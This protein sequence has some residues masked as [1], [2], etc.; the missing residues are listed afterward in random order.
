MKSL[1]QLP[2]F[3]YWQ[4]RALFLVFFAIFFLSLKGWVPKSSAGYVLPIHQPLP[5]TALKRPTKGFVRR[6]SRYKT[7]LAIYHASCR[8]RSYQY[9]RQNYQL[10]CLKAA[11]L[12]LGFYFFAP[13]LLLLSLCPLFLYLLNILS[14][15]N[16]KLTR[17]PEWFLIHWFIA[18]TQ[19]ATLI[20]IIILLGGH[21]VMA[22]FFERG[23]FQPDSLYDPDWV[24]ITTALATNHSSTRDQVANQLAAYVALRENNP[25]LSRREAAKKLGIPESTLRYWQQRQ[26]NIA[27][28][29]ALVAFFSS[30]QGEVFIHRLLVAR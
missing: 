29:P 6:R 8:Q 3:H 18:Y 11:F 25:D 12:A 26:N 4:S 10:T 17:Q 5:A 22:S 13:Q 21:L 16:P 28:N 20:V 2:T 23:S 14:L 7:R 15:L 9:M 27:A 19:L 30:P 1:Q 24:P